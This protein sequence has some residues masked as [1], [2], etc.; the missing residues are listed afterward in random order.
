MQVVGTRLRGRG[1]WARRATP[2]E[3]NRHIDW[4]YRRQGQIRR[5]LLG[6][7]RPGCCFLQIDA[8]DNVPDGT[9]YCGQPLQG[10]G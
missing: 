1:A 6:R 10:L 9:A 7:Y 3:G 8:A 2:D 4:P 5:P